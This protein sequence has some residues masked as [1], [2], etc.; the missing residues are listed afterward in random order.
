MK[1]KAK[2]L[3][4]CLLTAA[5]LLAV[6]FTAQAQWI[7]DDAGWKYEQSGMP[8]TNTWAQLDSSWYHFNSNGYMDTGWLTDNGA[9]YYLS[10]SGAMQTGTVVLDGMY[11]SFSPSGELLG[12]PVPVHIEGLDDTMLA[13]GIE[14]TDKYWNEINEMLVLLNQERARHGAAPLILDKDL[15]NIAGYRCAYMDATGYYE[16]YLDDIDLSNSVSSLYY[17]EYT[18]VGENLYSHYSKNNHPLSCSVMESAARGFNW[19][20]Q[21]PGHFSNMIDPAYHKVGLCIYSNS[22]NTK[23][24]FTQI[25]IY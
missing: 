3:S 8:M 15:C 14:Q 24:Y 13:A 17:G 4:A 1:F 16:H 11:H 18:N 2:I 5:Q 23:R 12:N 6:P 7:Q 19:Y 25:F 21:S 10:E 22:D 20:L 9:S